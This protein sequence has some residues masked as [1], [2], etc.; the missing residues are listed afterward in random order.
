MGQF[1]RD[2]EGDD[3]APLAAGLYRW[4]GNA[5]DTASNMTTEAVLVSDV[6]LASMERDPLVF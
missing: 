3:A 2:S 4:V 5:H 1:E 6:A